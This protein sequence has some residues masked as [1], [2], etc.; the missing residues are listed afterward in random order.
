MQAD[1]DDF[2]TR[3]TTVNLVGLY[4]ESDKASLF[5]GLPANADLPAALTALPSASTPF[6]GCVGDVTYNLQ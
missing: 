1:V 5:F 4:R 2:Y 6:I 3:D